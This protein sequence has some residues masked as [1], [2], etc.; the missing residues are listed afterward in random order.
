MRFRSRRAMGACRAAP[1]SSGVEGGPMDEQHRDR[2]PRYRTSAHRVS[3]RGSGHRGRGGRTWLGAVQR[4]GLAALDRDRAGGGRARSRD[5]L[6]AC[7]VSRGTRTVAAAHGASRRSRLRPDH[8][9]AVPPVRDTVVDDHQDG[10]ARRAR[11]GAA[12]GDPVRGAAQRHLDIQSRQY[13]PAARVRS[14]PALDRGHSRHAPGSSLG[15]R[16]RDQ[17]QFRLQSALVGPIVRDVPGAA[18]GGSRGHD[19]RARAVP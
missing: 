3:G 14:P 17:Q 18:G 11:S 16:E 6:P 15:D 1:S 12:G 19:R 5:L 8:R 4:S 7:H 10:R 13:R 9:G 2:H